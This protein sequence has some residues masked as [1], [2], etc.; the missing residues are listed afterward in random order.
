MAKYSWKTGLPK[1][2]RFKSDYELYIED[3]EKAI[4]KT[5]GSIA[6]ADLIEIAQ[7]RFTNEISRASDNLWFAIDEAIK[8]ELIDEEVGDTLK[9]H[10]KDSFTFESGVF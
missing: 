5:S 1:G 10:I 6:N 8:S 3:W 9:E 4:D 2:S 7:Q